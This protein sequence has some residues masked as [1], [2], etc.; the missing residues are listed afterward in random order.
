[1]LDWARVANLSE[2]DTTL[3]PVL[4]LNQEFLHEILREQEKLLYDFWNFDRRYKSLI[5]DTT[6]DPSNHNS[7]SSKHSVKSNHLDGTAEEFQ[8]RFPH[9]EASLESKA[10]KFIQNLQKYPSRVRWAA[11][12]REKFEKLLAQLVPLN[13]F[14]KSLL[15]SDQQAI[16]YQEQ[17]QTSM[18]ILQLNNKVDHLLQIVQAASIPLNFDKIA[19]PEKL[20]ALQISVHSRALLNPSD[21]LEGSQQENSLAKLARFKATIH[22][23]LLDDKFTV[24]FS[25]SNSTPETIS[26]RLDPKTC[27]VLRSKSTGLSREVERSE[28]LYDGEPV[29]I[30]WKYYEPIFEPGRCASYIEQRI[31]KLA[32][33][34]RDKEKPEGFHT[35]S[36]LGYFNDYERDSQQN[37]FGIVFRRPSGVSSTHPL[38]SLFELLSEDKP[39]LSNRVKLASILADSI[40]YLHSTNWVHKGLCSHNVVFFS[41]PGYTDLSNPYLCGFGLSRPAEIQEMTERPSNDPQFD[42]YRHPLAHGDAATEGIG[43]FKKTF[44]I[45]SLGIILMETAL[46]LPIHQILGIQSLEKGLRPNITKKVRSRLLNEQEHLARARSDIGDVFTEVVKTCLEGDFGIPL[47]LEANEEEAAKLQRS[48]HARVIKRLSSIKV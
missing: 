45:Y 12:D 9:D 44:D 16:L 17:M 37:R 26:L 10:L 40:Q 8:D 32:S 43:G 41:E 28:G 23:D 11:F 14:M 4:R 30:E 5:D 6:F 29:W 42:I 46:W 19:L 27:T 15:D 18:Q 36:C 1:M 22:S 33:L 2:H 35:P 21:K 3:S 24:A 48:F 20:Q 25:F 7:S 39:S 13:D 31:T 47:E 38:A 34:L